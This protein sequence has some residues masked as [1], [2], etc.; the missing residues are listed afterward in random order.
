MFI[1]YV[2]LAGILGAAL[3][4]PSP[5]AAQGLET[6]GSRAAAMGAFVAVADDAS[7]V[8]WNPAGLITGPIFNISIDLGRS[9][10]EPDGPP[11]PAGQAGRSETTLFALGTMPVGVAYYRIGTS[12]VDAF[13]PADVGIPGRQD[14]QVLVRTMVTTHLG[15]TVQ[16]SFWNHFTVGAAFKLVRA[17]LGSAIRESSTWDDA[18]DSSD[19]I[20]TPDFTRG[21]LDVGL[22]G[23]VGPLRAGLVVRNVT[24]PTFG[25]DEISDPAKLPRHARVGVAWG[26]RWPGIAGTILSFDADLTR[27]P[28]VGGERRDVAGGA[29]HWLAGRRF[30]VRGGV[31]ASTIG[32]TRTVV[33]G[34]GSV[35]IRSGFYVDGYVAGGQDEQR[36]WGIGARLTY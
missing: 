6:L 35:G 34:G 14:P 11:Q 33:S 21:D 4:T 13:S 7:A 24:E 12:T 36:A 3:I 27:L 19:V 16:Q 8:A 1:K 10:Q 5:A 18:L 30:G 26:N 2:G 15:V 9:E 29:E 32:E 23:A 17:E 25:E 31:R 20:D 22:M 28:A